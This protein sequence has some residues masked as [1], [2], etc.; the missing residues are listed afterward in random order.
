MPSPDELARRLRA[1]A[2]AGD[3]DGLHALID[4]ERTGTAAQ[5]Q[6]LADVDPEDRDRIAAQ[7]RAEIE[8]SAVDPDV[9]RSRLG[10]LQRDLARGD[11]RGA[12]DAV[13]VQRPG[14]EDLRL[15]IAPDGERVVLDPGPPAG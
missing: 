2:D 9:V 12:A 7:G 3:L 6:A 15:P 8:R 4:W 13:V 1:A 14:R 11:V 10:Q 5:E